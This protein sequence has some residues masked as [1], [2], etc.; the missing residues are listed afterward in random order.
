MRVE[1]TPQRDLEIVRGKGA[2]LIAADGHVYIDAGVSH[3]ACNVGHGHPEVVEAID[4]QARKLMF[5]GSSVRNDIRRAFLAAL[6]ELVPAPLERAFLSNSGTEAVEAAMKFAR[7]ATGRTRFVAAMRGFHG[8]TA[9]ALSLTWKEEFREPFG[10]LLADVDF[11]PYNDVE[12]LKTVV[13]SETA[14]VVLEPVQGEGGVHIGDPAYLRAARDLCSDRGTLLVL[15]EV[16]TGLGRTGRLFGFER[17]GIVPDLLCLAKSLAGGFPIGATILSADAHARLRGSHSSTFGGNPLACA[18]GAATL[19]VLVRERL[20]ERAERLGRAFL[21]DLRDTAQPDIRE[22]RG[23]GLMAAVEL[24]RKATPVLQ[25][26]MD[27]GV[28]ALSCGTSTVRFLPPLVI[29]PEDLR[30]AALAFEEAM[31]LG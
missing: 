31:A 27:R 14:A 16:Q 7:S 19:R 2:H 9:G 5:V 15:D 25:G 17:A 8:R 13:G 1:V 24:R 12:A 29:A 30:R 22:V 28:L 3:G 18:A 6:L 4:A 23:I 10:P 20:W 21:E 11:V 26:M